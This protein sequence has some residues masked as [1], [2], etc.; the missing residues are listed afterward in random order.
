MKA[1]T[2]S[3]FGAAKD[4]LVLEDLPKPKPSAGEVLVRMSYSSVNPSDVKVRSGA[5]GGD[6][7]FAKITPHSDGYGTIESVGE[8]VDPTRIGRKVWIWNGQW[9]RAFGT[10][11]EYIALPSVQAVD[12]PE[13]V[14]D[15]LAAGLGIPAMTAAHVVHAGGPVGETV[16]VNGANGTVGRLAVQF[17]ARAG[18][19]VIATTSDLKN[20]AN[21]K[22]LGADVVVNY[23]DAGAAQAVLDAT[24]G[25][26]VDRIVEVEFG[27]NINFDAKIIRTGGIIVAFG[28]AL[29]S[30]PE[31]PFMP[32]MFKNVRLIFA[33]VYVLNDADRSAA[34]KHVNAAIQS[35]DLVYPVQSQFDLQ[36]C[37]RAHEAVEAGGRDGIVLLKT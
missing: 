12:L 29:S 25:Q 18:A 13:G 23:R 11:A 36:D 22:S 9:Q 17:A 28:S 1:I 14:D 8:G 19:R 7:P 26:G 21:L 31:I 15:R 34:I 27:L 30:A 6:M 33:L 10:A 35:G 2:Y 3:G 32:L 5:R 24:A 37:A 20:T 16:L 4:V